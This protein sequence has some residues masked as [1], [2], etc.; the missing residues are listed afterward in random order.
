[1]RPTAQ[2]PRLALRNSSPARGGARNGL[3]LVMFC[4]IVAACGG[5][6]H[7]VSPPATT[8]PPATTNGAT[9]TNGQSPN[10]L[11]GEAGSAATGDIPDNQVFVTFRD[12]RAGYS[13]KYPEGWAQNG[14]GTRVAFRD[15]NNVVRVVVQAGSPETVAG[16]RAE[17]AALTRAAPSL[18]FRAPAR[19]SIGRAPAIEVV[20]GTESPPNQVTNKRVKLTVNRFYL[21]HAG[22]RAV[23][24][25]GTPVG[26]DNVDAYRLMIQS[27]RWR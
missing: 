23:V 15:K 17:M 22:K 8:A 20:Y 3:P 16:V 2:S 24:D 9:T 12:V 13:M 6:K 1:M 11:Q 27:F 10:A 5:T 25:L 26:V 14:T 7:A 21:W 19:I 18:Q 4:L